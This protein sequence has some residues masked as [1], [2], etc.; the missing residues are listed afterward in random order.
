MQVS[1][2]I[3]AKE[4]TSAQTV[5]MHTPLPYQ[6]RQQK[7]LSG[8]RDKLEPTQTQLDQFNVCRNKS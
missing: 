7:N 1:P 2:L 3:T 6:L 8:D 5:L 4:E